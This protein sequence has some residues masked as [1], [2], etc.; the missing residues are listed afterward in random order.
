MIDLT[1]ERPGLANRPNLFVGEGERISVFGSEEF[2]GF[3]LLP[4]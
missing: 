2:R 1:E 4:V 3:R